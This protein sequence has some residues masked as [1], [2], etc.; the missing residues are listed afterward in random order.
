MNVLVLVLVL[1]DRWV[2]NPLEL[3]ANAPELRV[4]PLLRPLLLV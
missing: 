1:E 2:I 3:E 4:A